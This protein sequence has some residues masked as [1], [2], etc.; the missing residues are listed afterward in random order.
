MPALV[1]TDHVATITWLGRVAD[2]DARLSS[3]PVERLDLS[4]AGAEGDAHSGLTRPSCSRVVAQYPR[5]TV[6]RNVRQLTILSSE[7]LA[8]IAADMGLD[9]LAPQFLGTSIVIEG[10]AD[11]SHVP[12][13]S[14][15]QAESGTTLTIDMENR[16]C[17]LPGR[18]IEAAYPGFGKAFKAAAAGRR[19][20]TA[21]VEREGRLVLGERLR[22]HVPSQ[23]AWAVPA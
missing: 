15:L 14:R 8:G 11:F 18:E 6:I 23:R 4:F 20:V 7:E 22:L 17:N 19:G 21:W 1:P 13:S 2:R 10:I 16:P 3:D 9:R 5:A 12:P